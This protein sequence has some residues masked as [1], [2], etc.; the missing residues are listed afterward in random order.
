MLKSFKTHLYVLLLVGGG[1]LVIALVHAAI[2]GGG[3]LSSA[4][5]TNACTQKHVLSDFFQTALF[6]SKN[7]QG[8]Q[9]I[10][11]I[12]LFGP[13]TIIL[14][15]NCEISKYFL[16]KNATKNHDIKNLD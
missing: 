7:V 9:K 6:R 2:L 10:G 16:A 12:V 4:R 13:L 3:L 11:L 5:Q 1:V 8:I 14:S 15:E